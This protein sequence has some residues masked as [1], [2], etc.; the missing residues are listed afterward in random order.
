MPGR[1]AAAKPLGDGDLLWRVGH[2]SAPLAA[3]PARV[4]SFLGRYDDVERRRGTVYA[5][6]GRRTAL[7]EAL[8]PLRP[9]ASA[10]QA[11]MDL[12]G[13]APPPAR[14]GREWRA[15]RVLVAG[16]LVT[17]GPFADIRRV[18][19]RHALEV[20]H[21]PQLAQVGIARL[22]LGA[23]LGPARALTQQLGRALH[24][25]GHAGVAYPST[26]D[27]QP[28]AALFDERAALVRPD[29]PAV[30]PLLGHVPELVEVCAELGLTL[31]A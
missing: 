29:T 3:P 4:A 8:A 1:R 19:L 16:R 21:T 5:A 6:A 23:A 13:T 7:R 31:T 20:T 25:G 12:H 18:D 28:C 27:G 14:V 2:A 9:D 15:Q 30:E 10:R 11:W 17:E 26:S 24:A 22:D